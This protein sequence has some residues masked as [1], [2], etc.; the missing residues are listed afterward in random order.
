MDTVSK[1]DNLC[2]V[3]F[4]RIQK[5]LHYQ[6]PTT[7][8]LQAIVNGLCALTYNTGLGLTPLNPMNP[9]NFEVLRGYDQITQR[10]YIFVTYATPH[11]MSPANL[12]GSFLMDTSRPLAQTIGVP[13]P[14]SDLVTEW[15]GLNLWRKLPGSLLV[16]SGTHRYG[17]HSPPDPAHD[18]TTVFHG[19]VANTM[20]RGLAHI[21]LHGFNNN[22]LPDSDIV[23]SSG[24]T[25]P[26]QQIR[27]LARNLQAHDFRVSNN[28]DGN[29]RELIGKANSQGKA[30]KT[31]GSP[32]I[33]LEMNYS[34]RAIP[35]RWQVVTNVIAKSMLET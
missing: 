12:W 16:I 19:V 24:V 34:I 3:A 4:G 10:P 33:H 7:A 32:F 27:Q 11:N 20:Q 13:H 28:W 25:T 23:V 22:S 15:I 2:S 8:E 9:M 30:A 18:D 21:Q 1:L 14:K 6:A 29:N 35:A 26:G 5:D 31:A 17:Q